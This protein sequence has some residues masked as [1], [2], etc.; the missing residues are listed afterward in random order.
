[1]LLAA[2]DG[3]RSALSVSESVAFSFSFG[4]RV[5]QVA[6]LQ[7]KPEALRSC[8][9]TKANRPEEFFDVDVA[10][11]DL[12]LKFILAVAGQEERGERELGPI[13]L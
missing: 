7:P 10:R 1:M 11:V 9:A 13:H 2:E 8:T 4:I 6:S 12:L 3:P 5:R